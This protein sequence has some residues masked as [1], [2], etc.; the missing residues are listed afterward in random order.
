MNNDTIFKS[1][2]NV[3]TIMEDEIL[4]LR[5]DL[6]IGLS[7][8]TT[9]PHHQAIA[10]ERIRYT[11][12]TL[13][14]D[15]IFGSR[16]NKLCQKLKLITSTKIAEC[17]DEPWD[18]FI[19]ILIYYKLTAIL[20]GKGFIEFINISGDTI[21]DDLEFTYY[22]DMLDTDITDDDL[23]W[24]EHLKKTTHPDIKTLW[25]HRDDTSVNEDIDILEP[26]WK[27]LGLLWEKPSITGTKIKTNNVSK[28]KPRIIK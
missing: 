24:I 7:F 1:S 2:I 11:I 14:Q 20:S 18:Q 5:V 6:K 15:S 26:T 10:L 21:S 23:D 16:R 8:D 4:P 12:N 9:N 27:M 3:I 17:W 22:A 28:F 19:A 13:F 25:Y